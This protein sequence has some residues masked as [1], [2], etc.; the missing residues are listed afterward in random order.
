MMLT[1]KIWSKILYLATRPPPWCYALPSTIYTPFLSSPEEN[2][3]GHLSTLETRLS[4]VLVS[5]QWY[6]LGTPYLYEFLRLS[7]SEAF[8]C[9]LDALE[10]RRG[11]GNDIAPYIRVVVLPYEPRPQVSPLLILAQ[12][13]NLEVIIRSRWPNYVW[14]DPS[15]RPIEDLDSG[16]LPPPPPYAPSLDSLSDVLGEVRRVDCYENLMPARIGGIDRLESL[17]QACPGVEYLSIQGYPC[18]AFDIVPLPSLTT[19]RIGQYTSLRRFYKTW[20]MPNL[21]HVAIH[22]QVTHRLFWKHFGQNLHSVEIIISQSSV[23]DRNGDELSDILESCPNLKELSYHVELCRSPIFRNGAHTS[24]EHIRIHAGH[25]SPTAVPSGTLYNHVSSHFYA[26]TQ[27]TVP[28]LRKVVL[29]GSWEEKVPDMTSILTRFEADGHRVE[30]EMVDM[31]L[32][33]GL[34]PEDPVPDFL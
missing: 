24:L 28:A 31:N 16:E 18:D 11:T 2:L 12:L 4:V 26:Y 30:K 34:S 8:Y 23:P 1:S 21:R 6:S 9:L 19:L 15:T 29:Y 17:L 5:R 27:R 22:V 3:H 20:S 10:R 25:A 7:R 33:S 14:P 32:W 13:P